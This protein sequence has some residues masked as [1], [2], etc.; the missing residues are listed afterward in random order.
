MEDHAEQHMEQVVAILA[1]RMRVFAEDRKG[2]GVVFVLGAGCSMQYGLPSFQQILTSIYRETHHPL[3]VP[4]S[5]TELREKMDPFWRFPENPHERNKLLTKLLLRHLGA[6]K[7]AWCRGYRDLAFLAVRGYVRAIVNMN[8]DRLLHEALETEVARGEKET[9]RPGRIILMDR[10]G[11]LKDP[12]GWPDSGIEDFCLVTPHGSLARPSSKL[13]LD[14]ASSDL[15]EEHEQERTKERPSSEEKAKRFFRENNVV[16]VG[17]SGGDAK[18]AQ[19]LTGHS[20]RTNIFVFNLSPPGSHVLRAVSARNSAELYVTGLAAT[21]ERLM[22]SL[23]RH[24]SG[25]S[26][27]W[28][29]RGAGGAG[30]ARLGGDYASLFTREEQ[31]ALERC[32]LFALRQRSS[33]NVAEASE[34]SIDEHAHSLFQECMQLATRLGCPLT[35]AER[36]LV[37]SAAF[38]HDLGYFYA[39]SAGQEPMPGWKLLREHGQLT[40]TLL[41]PRLKSNLE[42]ALKRIVPPSFVPPQREDFSKLLLCLCRRHSIPWL[43]ADEEAELPQGPRFDRYEVPIRFELVHKLFV[44]AEE[45]T[46]GHPFLPS[47]YR[48]DPLVQKAIQDPLLDIYL[49]KGTRVAFDVVKA[50]PEAIAVVTF[51]PDDLRDGHCGRAAEWFCTMAHTALAELQ[52]A[53]ERTVDRHDEWQHGISR[54]LAVDCA[55]GD[56]HAQLSCQLDT[57]VKKANEARKKARKDPGSHPGVLFPEA[58]VEALE[59]ALTGSIALLSKRDTPQAH[60]DLRWQ[61]KAALDS[62]IIYTFDHQEDGKKLD[63]AMLNAYDCVARW[64]EEQP[65]TASL[66]DYFPAGLLPLYFS[67]KLQ[68][69]ADLAG[70][71]SAFIDAFEEVYYPAWKLCAAQWRSGND[72]VCMARAAL[73]FGSSCRRGEVIEGLRQ[74][75]SD[76]I[77]P[78]PDRH[79]A[80][81]HGRCM[82]CTGRLLY[83]LSHARLLFPPAQFWNVVGYE[84]GPLKL[85]GILAYL[86]A[87]RLKEACW[88]GIGED[89]AIRSADYIA[90]GLRGLVMAIATDTL[91]EGASD[92]GDGWLG[93]LRQEVREL[94]EVILGYLAAAGKEVVFSKRAEE[95]RSF[96]LGEVATTYLF[97]DWLAKLEPSIQEL[98]K[99]DTL[100]RC[101]DNLKEAFE[102]MEKGEL[103][104]L[105][106]YYA[107]PS[108]LLVH[109]LTQEAER[110]QALAQRAV[111]IAT[112]CARSRVWVRDGAGK[113]SWGNNL[114]NTQRLASCLSVFW[115][116]AFDHKEDFAGLFVSVV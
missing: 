42:E 99:E 82:L 95:P 89:E 70:M 10:E 101:T 83:I 49:M 116:Y 23:R 94:P 67:H 39:Y 43:P 100:K 53:V 2:P 74:L 31:V 106:S 47:P 105:D 50:P 68:P 26:E 80:Y 52:G 79:W 114:E 92:S 104:Q 27:C 61:L 72:V 110:K 28:T 4:Q 111:N 109:Q 12:E 11:W 9:E 17:Y 103:A 51:K 33:L 113:G 15:F 60:I 66:C 76:K 5:L 93:D 18:M 55:L 22:E 30:D 64:L 112:E 73:D 88:W 13:V 75:V 1:A 63:Q 98:F 37:Y 59:E 8:F 78:D 84:E 91:M 44:A 45:I 115:R 38:F 40:E 58:M 46:E 81:G 56:L 21:F 65:G 102:E 41:S 25:D 35:T 71:E 32:R 90:W 96:I 69:D 19:V 57:V 14:I 87:V 3:E 6:M 54:T 108:W 86:T 24:L 48:F 85:R 7:G 107:L 36:Y 16:V 77:A 34:I 62:I 29:V 20:D 97:L